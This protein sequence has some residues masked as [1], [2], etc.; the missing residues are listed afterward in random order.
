MRLAMAWYSYPFSV[1]VEGV[2]CSRTRNRTLFFVSLSLKRT[3]NKHVTAV[4]SKA[5]AI[6][7]HIL[8]KMHLQASKLAKRFN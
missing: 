4:H 5:F 7:V 3:Q 6:T 1:S 2:L 8:I